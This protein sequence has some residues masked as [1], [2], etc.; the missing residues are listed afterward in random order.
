MGLPAKLSVK[1]D[2]E[3]KGS[4]LIS[5]LEKAAEDMKEMAEKESDHP[6]LANEIRARVRSF[7][8][9]L[10]LL[11]AEL[12]HEDV[13]Q[14]V[15]FFAGRKQDLNRLRGIHVPLEMDFYGESCN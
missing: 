10:C 13:E 15:D 14:A 9:G 7:E 1:L 12:R 2:K 5:A 6:N 4:V 11:G 8:E 3:V